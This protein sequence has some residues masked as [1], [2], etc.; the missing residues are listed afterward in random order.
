MTT[1]VKFRYLKIL[2]KHSNEVF[3]HR[4]FPSLP[5]GGSGSQYQF[6]NDKISTQIKDKKNP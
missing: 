1:Q 6:L 4:Y 5:S 2:L 3:V